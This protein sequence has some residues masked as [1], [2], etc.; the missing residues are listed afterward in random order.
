[1]GLF[2]PIEGEFTKLEEVK[3]NEESEDASNICYERPEGEVVLLLGH[4][5][6]AAAQ[7]HLHRSQSR[8]LHEYRQV[9]RLE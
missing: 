7:D 6:A 4:C 3:S 5:D 9:C 2:T 1:M 8:G